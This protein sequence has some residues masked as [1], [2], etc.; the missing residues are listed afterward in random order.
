MS[1]GDIF[2][3]TLEMLVLKAL[4][5][6]PMH[7]YGINKWLQS[8]G[9][10]TL[11]VNEGALYPALQRL[12]VQ[13]YVAEAWDRTPNGREAKFYTLLPPGR[14][15]LTSEVRRWQE[16]TSAVQAVLQAAPA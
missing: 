9:G 3:G 16:H 13:G 11:K 5:W 14:A 8:H 1:G 7:G 10:A 2:T 4:C 15:R 12:V 6:Q